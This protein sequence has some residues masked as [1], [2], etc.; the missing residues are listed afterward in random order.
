MLPLKRCSPD[1]ALLFGDTGQAEIR[2][3]ANDNSSDFSSS[4]D[5]YVGFEDNTR[6]VIAMKLKHE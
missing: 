1:M 4:A 5:F 2:A 6:D 3:A